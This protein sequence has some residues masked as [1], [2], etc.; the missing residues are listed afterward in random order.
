M[1]WSAARLM[2]Q[3][4]RLA[5]HCLGLGLA[6][7]LRAKE[8]PA[9]HHAQRVRERRPLNLIG[10]GVHFQIFLG[11]RCYSLGKGFSFAQR[12]RVSDL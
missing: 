12:A 8:D 11:L 4:E 7:N 1:F 5:L 2:P 6:I 10:D 9:C 3:R